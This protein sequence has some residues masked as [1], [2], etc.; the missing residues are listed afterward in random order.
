MNEAA[1]TGAPRGRFL[2]T[3]FGATAELKRETILQRQKE[4]IAIAKAAGTEDGRSIVLTQ[5]VL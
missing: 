5:R 2:L 4:D 1:D 3:A